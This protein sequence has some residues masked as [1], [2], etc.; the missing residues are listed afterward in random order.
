[1]PEQIT[2]EEIRV[3]VCERGLKVTQVIDAVVETNDHLR[4]HRLMNFGDSLRDYC[5]NKLPHRTMPVVRKPWPQ[6][7]GGR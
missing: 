3:L 5:Y 4:S 1:V 7:A 2:P 6:T